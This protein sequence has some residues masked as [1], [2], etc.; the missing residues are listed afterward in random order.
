MAILMRMDWKD[1]TPEQYDRVRELVNWEGDQPTGAIAHV[2]AFDD[3]GAHVNDI[4]ASAADFD[5][6]V[7]DRLMA[8]VA[9]VGIETQPDITIFEAHAVYI[10]GVTH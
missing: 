7:A 6:F 10:P 4:W 2:A 8:G 9:E 3:D 5:A 1:V